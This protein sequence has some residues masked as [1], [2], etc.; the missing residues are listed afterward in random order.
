MMFSEFQILVRNKGAQ[1][2]TT[3]VQE[4]MAG[5][6]MGQF[7]DPA[8]AFYVQVPNDSN[9]ACMAPRQLPQV[10]NAVR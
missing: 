9:L 3:L 8:S 4:T 7:S 10:A 5:F 6:C 1:P 2:N